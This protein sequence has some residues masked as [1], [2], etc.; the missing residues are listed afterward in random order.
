MRARSRYRRQ[1]R[2]IIRATKMCVHLRALHCVTLIDKPATC[3][4][5]QIMGFHLI[6]LQIRRIHTSPGDENDA[7]D[8][9]V[10]GHDALKLCSRRR[11]D[12]SQRLFQTDFA[13]ISL[14]PSTLGEVQSPECTD[15]DQHRDHDPKPG[16]A[17]PADCFDQLRYP[18]ARNSS[19]FRMAAPAAPRMV[20]CESTVNL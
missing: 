4:L 13:D 9:G 2:P 20:L 16:S 8:F 14:K 7:V 15:H 17:L 5:S 19:P 1:R 10:L 6:K 12:R 18:W 11:L 3:K